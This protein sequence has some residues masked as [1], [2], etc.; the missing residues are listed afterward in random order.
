MVYT[1]NTLAPII[2]LCVMHA[3]LVC[4]KSTWSVDVFLAL[5]HD[6]TCKNKRFLVMIPDLNTYVDMQ[7][8]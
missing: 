5:Y 4:A 1:V 8:I 2:L 7:R 6:K 3:N